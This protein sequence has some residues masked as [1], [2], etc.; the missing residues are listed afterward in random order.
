[1]SATASEARQPVHTVYGGAHLFRADTAA[2]LGALARQ[3][4][5][6]YGGDAAEFAAVVGVAPQL[7]EVLHT[8]VCEKLQREP[9]EDFRVDFEDGFGYR[10]ESEEDLHA[11]RAAEEMARGWRDGGLPPFIGLR[12]KPLTDTSRTRALRTLQLFFD[13]LITGTGGE[14]PANFAVTLPKITSVQQVRE[15]VE[16]LEKL[17]SEHGLQPGSVPIELMVETPRAIFAEDGRLALPML[18]QSANGRCRGAHF[19]PYDY[20]GSLDIAGEH[21]TL[22]HPACG[23]ARQAMQVALAGSGIFLSDG[24][25]NILPVPPHRGDAL[26]A[27]QEAENRRVVHDAW[28]LHAENIRR[29]LRDGFY[30]SWD[31]HP[32]QLPVRYAAVYA[33]FL[34]GLDAATG[35]LRNFVNQAAQATMVGSVFDDA[36][37]GQGLL[38]FFLRGLNCG[39]LTE[40]EAQAT[41]LSVHE[42]RSRSFVR[43]SEPHA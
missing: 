40:S 23:F 5:E 20:T 29:S 32:A 19:G 27:E 13:S 35:R 15:L 30:Q 24:P 2:R 17:E 38:N 4:I 18:V 12:I 7:A 26:T 3:S 34:E 6:R 43:V 41:G 37:T 21:Q 1:M 39:A 11:R 14:L 25:T 22:S 31:V 36:A 42:L 10:P 9:V 33:F 28:R 8:R 16:T